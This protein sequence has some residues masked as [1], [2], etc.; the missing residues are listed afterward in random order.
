MAEKVGIDHLES[1]LG[2]VL[3]L[4][5]AVV[6]VI[7]SGKFGISD[8]FKLVGLVKEAVSAFKNLS[9]V[10]DE[11]KDLSDDEKAALSKFV[12]SKLDIK[13]P[14]IKGY[15]EQA[16]SFVLGLLDVYGLFKKA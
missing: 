14:A 16:I 4:A 11:V 1:L 3:D 6:G 9:A 15:V 2:F 13:D 10:R 5:S 12:E 7:E 8:G